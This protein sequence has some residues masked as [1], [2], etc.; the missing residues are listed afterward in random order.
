MAWASSGLAE[1]VYSFTCPSKLIQTTRDGFGSSLAR[2][3]DETGKQFK[4]SGPGLQL[5]VLQFKP[6][7]DSQHVVQKSCEERAKKCGRPAFWP[8]W[9]QVRNS[10]HHHLHHRPTPTAS[11]PLHFLQLF[12][13]LNCNYDNVGSVKRFYYC[14]TYLNTYLNTY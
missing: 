11:T 14:Y 3:G 8:Q 5:V 12:F 10:T 6:L 2:T 1:P 4:Q 9:S 13:C 7:A